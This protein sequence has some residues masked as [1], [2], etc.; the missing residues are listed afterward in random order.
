[1]TKQEAYKA[2]HAKFPRNLCWLDFDCLPTKMCLDGDFTMEELREVMR[3]AEAVE[4]EL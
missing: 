1:M 4:C 3:L 2:F